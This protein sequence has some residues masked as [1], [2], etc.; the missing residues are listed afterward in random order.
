MKMITE[1]NNICK[2][3]EEEVQRATEK[4]KECKEQLITTSTTN[5]VP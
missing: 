3:M 1:M 4:A 5:A 2:K